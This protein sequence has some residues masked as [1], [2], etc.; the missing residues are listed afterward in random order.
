MKPHLNKNSAI[1]L[2]V[3]QLL[4]KRFIEECKPLKSQVEN[5]HLIITFDC[6]QGNLAVNKKIIAL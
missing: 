1:H 2:Q 4:L 5:N 6:E 3:G